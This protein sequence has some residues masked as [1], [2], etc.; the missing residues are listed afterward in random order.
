VEVNGGRRIRLTT[1]PPSVSRLSRKCGS[2]HVLLRGYLYL[3]LLNMGFSVQGQEK[4]KQGTCMK[5]AQ[6][7]ALFTIQSESNIR[8]SVCRLDLQPAPCWIPA[9]IAVEHENLAGYVPPKRR[10]ILAGLRGDISR[11]ISIAT[12][13]HRCDNPVGNSEIIH[14]LT[15]DMIQG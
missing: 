7:I 6:T 8:T 13:S 2:L 12:H 9:W 1:S 3:T 4:S 11:K 15:C 10:L 5:Q 14:I